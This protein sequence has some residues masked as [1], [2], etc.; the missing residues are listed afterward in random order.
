MSSPLLFQDLQKLSG[1][2][3]LCDVERW[4]REQRIPFIRCKDGIC[5]TIEAVNYALGVLV[6]SGEKAYRPDQVF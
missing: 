3:R 4:A 6:Q 1:Y 2:R 5:T